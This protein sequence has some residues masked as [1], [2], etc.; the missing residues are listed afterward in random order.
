[1]AKS[2]SPIIKWFKRI[3]WL[4]LI[5]VA[6]SILLLSS[7]INQFKNFYRHTLSAKAGLE[8]ALQALESKNLESAGASAQKAEAEFKA[9]LLEL[10]ST[11]DNFLIKN[12]YFFRGQIDDLAA[13][14]QAGLSLS[15]AFS[16]GLNIVRPFQSALVDNQGKKFFEFP[17]SDKALIL[18]SIKDSEAEFSKLQ[19]DLDTAA[20]NLES[21]PKFSIL[22][23][24]HKQ[25]DDLRI[26][27]EAG[28][29]LLLAL[30]PWL[31][32]APVIAGYPEPSRFLLLL[33]NT[34]ELRP[35]G[36]FL[37]T[38]GILE[39]SG[40]EIKT[41]VTEDTYH[42]D[43]PV[44]DTLTTTPPLV[45]KTY[46]KVDKWFLRDSN[47]SPDWPTAAK[48]IQFVYREELNL[49]KQADSGF[50]G[51][52]GITPDLISD[53]IRLTG[54]I[55]VKGQEYNQDNFQKLLQ[56]N[57]EVAYKDDNISSWDRKEIINDIIKEL[58][59][60]LMALPLS[61]VQDLVLLLERNLEQKNVLVY[62]NNPVYQ[63]QIND[64]SW[65]GRV[66]KSAGDY[67]MVV[68]ANLAA[69]K[70]D[71]VMVKS[72][73]YALKARDEYEAKLKLHYRHTGGFDW[74]TT[75]YR[76]YTRVYVPN[77]SQIVSIKGEEPGTLNVYY[78]PALDKN[79]FAF[80]LVVEPG[81]EKTIEIDYKLSDQLKKEMNADNYSLLVQKQPG[82][83]TS[84]LTVGLDFK[85][86]VNRYTSDLL[87][88][89]VF[90][91]KLEE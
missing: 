63:D 83:R 45:L 88:D 6:L 91:L 10:D 16:R 73:D 74:R 36:G 61:R 13:L 65:A 89:K 3:L 22:Y 42:L 66:K 21:I 46:L 24:V 62:F 82:R 18:Q 33:Q 79:V 41:L 80:F 8:T 90:Q 28:R 32:L 58:K 12:L 86:R 81:K 84:Q 40:G 4:F 75:R 71:A 37:G 19:A 44:K 2:R 26:K 11:R 15:Q 25:I 72:I 29:E 54:P 43:M 35:T 49:L 17:G 57:V 27:V 5:L 69:F 64:L 70:S 47:W 78:D 38:Y 60:R 67:L 77:G 52:I 20:A 50:S 7:S 1:M 48:D 56:Y 51:V 85:N 34:D 76:S 87:T 23:P 55:S 39:L 9:A 59:D 30:R 14:D 53:L 68:D 31:R